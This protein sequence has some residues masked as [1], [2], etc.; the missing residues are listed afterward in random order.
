MQRPKEAV[1]LRVSMTFLGFVPY[2]TVSVASRIRRP[3]EAVELGCVRQRRVRQRRARANARLADI[4]ARLKPDGSNFEEIARLYSDDT[5]TGKDG[6]YQ[7]D[8]QR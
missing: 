5:K 6:F 8:C 2:S 3:E 4:K 1:K 7:W